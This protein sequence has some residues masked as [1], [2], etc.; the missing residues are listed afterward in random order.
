MTTPAVELATGGDFADHYALS[1]LADA[2][3]AAVAA[4]GAPAEGEADLNLPDLAPASAL[5]Q[6]CGEGE[7]WGGVGWGGGN[8][9]LA[10]AELAPASVQ[11]GGLDARLRQ[12]VLLQ[13][14]A[15]AEQQPCFP[16]GSCPT[17]SVC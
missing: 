6:V 17:F 12:G 3:E 15:M 16:E 14:A 11:V 1:V 10:L 5:V 9:K 2:N 7:V 4:I 8:A 13:C